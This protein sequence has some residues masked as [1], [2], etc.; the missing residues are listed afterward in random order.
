MHRY[1]NIPG[2]SLQATRSH[3]LVGLEPPLLEDSF[4]AIQKIK[5]TGRKDVPN[6]VRLHDV[7]ER[8][9]ETADTEV[10]NYKKGNTRHQEA[11]RR[12]IVSTW[13][14]DAPHP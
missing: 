7:L 6:D 1:L 5:A 10:I 4:I 2:H 8:T 13:V 12:A 11:N 3:W 9:T 14:H